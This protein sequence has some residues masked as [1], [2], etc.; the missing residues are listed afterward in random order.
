[1]AVIFHLDMD[2]FYA[3]IEQ[4]DQPALRGRPVIVGGPVKRGVVSTASYEARPFGVHSAMPMARALQLCPQAVVLPVRMERYAAVSRQ[5][6]EVLAGY[7]PRIEPL[8]QDEAF[9]DMSG[10]ERMFGPPPVAARRIQQHVARAT[11]LSCS[12]GVAG[13]KFL[14][15]LASDLDKPG[16]ITCVPCG[17]EREF[18]APLPVRRIWGVGPKAARRLERLGL[19]RIGD[20]AAADPAWLEAELG[21]LGA[22]IHDLA[23]GLD[24]RPV[25]AERERK[26]V[27]S[28]HT[29][30]LDIH[31]RGPVEQHLRQACERV[32]RHL[33][34]QRLRAR[35]VRVKL[36]YAGSFQLATR[37]GRLPLACDD[38][39]TL[40]ATARALLERLD[41][42]APIRLVG[43]AATQLT[44]PAQPVQGDLFAGAQSE[45]QAR[46]ER[47]LDAIHDRFGERI[48]RAGGRCDEDED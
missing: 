3:A 17:R 34:R 47:T 1:M 16:G 32:A 41:L 14:A 4:H 38:S 37:D 9:L 36:R 43:A 31:G 19:R 25:L 26:S 35:G 8:S 22:H 30:E 40:F 10:T 24:Q 42:Q 44:E 2:A 13:N 27:G 7:S 23:C 33:R 48:E 6:M 15:K 28:E 46:L 11:G 5:L 12:L 21:G 18:I 39:A 45:R 20:V 29:L